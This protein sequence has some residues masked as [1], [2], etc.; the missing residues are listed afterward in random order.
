M[1]NKT[2]VL[3]W[4]C[5]VI[6]SY[7]CGDLPICR[8]CMF[9]GYD[10]IVENKPVET[11]LTQV[12]AIFFFIY[13]CQ[14]FIDFTDWVNSPI[15]RLHW[16]RDFTDWDTSPIER[17]RRLRDYTYWETL[18]IK[19]LY[20]LRNLPKWDTSPIQR[21][22]R[23]RDCTDWEISPIATLHRMRDF[24]KWDTSPNDSL[25]RV[26]EFTDFETSPSFRIH[27]GTESIESKLHESMFLLTLYTN[28][29]RQHR[30]KALPMC[31]PYHRTEQKSCALRRHYS[32]LKRMGLITEK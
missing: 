10:Q 7:I 12:V 19:R 23:S 29:Y 22:H 32:T 14:R 1:K 2:F 16:L 6:N 4:S 25:Q 17:L 26:R 31:W 5:S 20:R 9:K 3:E 21:L 13:V 24:T 28:Q 27:W 15:E 30:I 18:P 8:Y 11:K